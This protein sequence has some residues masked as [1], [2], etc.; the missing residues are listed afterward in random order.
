MTTLL[1]QAIQ[2]RQ[3]IRIRYNNKWRTVEPYLVGR[4][5]DTD[6]PTLR[7]Y[8]VDAPFEDQS[9]Q[10]QHWR[11]FTVAK[12]E[13][14]EQTT[15]TFRIRADYDPVDDNILRVDCRA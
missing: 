12:I 2:Q 11:L 13:A 9:S 4:H 3:V 5:N 1:C 10:R 6:K 14:I 15:S 8:Y 7:A